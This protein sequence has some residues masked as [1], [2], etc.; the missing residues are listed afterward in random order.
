MTRTGKY[1]SA[2]SLSCG[3]N[4]LYLRAQIWLD[5]SSYRLLVR[6]SGSRW[7]YIMSE[8][9]PPALPDHLECFVS[10]DS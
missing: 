9:S 8:A 10:L 5:R 4:H 7:A 1:I 6:C 2:R 3:R